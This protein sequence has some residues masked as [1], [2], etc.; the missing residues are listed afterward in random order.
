M[1][2]LALIR[3]VP[4]TGGFSEWEPFEEDSQFN[5]DWWNGSG[6]YEDDAQRYSWWSLMDR[7]RE[8]ARLEL[9]RE[10]HLDEY[11][12]VPDLGSAVCEIQLIEVVPGLRRS[13]IGR[14]VMHVLAHQHP[15][16]RLLAFSEEANEFWAGLGWVRFNH[17]KGSPPN[18]PLF[19]APSGWGTGAG[20]GAAAD[21]RA[22]G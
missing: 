3:H 20:D 5:A 4:P 6:E 15:H 8:V 13:G 11:S 17:R 18:R 7:Q 2:R 14:Q 22:D 21:C 10:V 19:V 16:A 12:A 9:D 1:T